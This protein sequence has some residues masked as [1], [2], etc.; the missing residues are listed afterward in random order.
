MTNLVKTMSSSYHMEQKTYV[1]AS[2]NYNIYTGENIFLQFL[3]SKVCE[4]F[5]FGQINKL[6]V[7]FGLYEPSFTF[8]EERKP[9]KY[10]L[11]ESNLISYM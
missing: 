1:E 4:S 3:L 10:C 2:C 11:S 7:Y 9:N 5:V 8:I 6:E